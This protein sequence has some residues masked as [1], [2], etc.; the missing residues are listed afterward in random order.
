MDLNTVFFT[1]F[2]LY[3]VIY[4]VIAQG[5]RYNDVE[6]NLLPTQNDISSQFRLKASEKGVRL[7]YLNLKIGN[8][9][10]HPL[11]LHDEYLA[12][13][14]VWANNITEPML[15]L[16]DDYDILSLGLLNYQVRSIDVY[17][18][19]QPS[20]CLASLNS[21]RQNLAVGRMLLENVTTE[22]S[23]DQLSRK[24][25]VHVV[26]VAVIEDNVGYRGIVYRCC[27]IKTL[28][29][30]QPYGPSM[31]QCD[32]TVE[33]SSHWM[34]M[35]SVI[36][37]VMSLFMT[38]YLPALPLA[39][40]DCIFSLQYECDKEDGAEA[41][42]IDS[43][44]AESAIRRRN[45][46]E[47]ISGSRE[48]EG[49]QGE[50]SRGKVEE[51]EASEIPVDDSSPVTCSAL[52]QAYIQ[53]LP[54]SRLSFNIKLAVMLYCIL[55]CVFYV[56]IGLWLTFKKKYIYES[57]KKQVQLSRQTTSLITFYL[58]YFPYFYVLPALAGLALLIFLRPKDLLFRHEM[59]WLCRRYFPL[60]IIPFPTPTVY[61]PR[62][63]PDS[64]GN[65]I[66]WH[67]RRVQQLPAF[68]W[69]TSTQLH[70]RLWEKLLSFS[71]C[72]LSM[73][74][75]HESRLK[76]ALCVLCVLFFTLPA[77]LIGLFGECLILL[78]LIVIVC[79][80]LILFSPCAILLLLFMIGVQ[81]K[82]N[83]RRYGVNRN[84]R[85]RK[86]LV[87]TISFVSSASIVFV[88]LFHLLMNSTSFVTY[89]LGFI[90]IGLYLN[91][92][93][94]RPYVA[95][96]LVVITNIYL[97]YANLQNRYREFKGLLLK[98]HQKHNINNGDQ[99]TIPTSLFWFVS[100]R[101]LPIATETCQM[102]CNMTL[103]LIF[104]SLF[105]CA[106]LFFKETYS[107][108]S[109]TSTVSVFVS[110]VIP[111]LFFKG[112]TKGEVFSGWEKIK[113]KREIK[114]AVEEF[115]PEKP[116]ANSASGSMESLEVL[117]Q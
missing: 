9:S 31:I 97:C 83:P 111:G 82:L 23:A 89:M 54:D 32:L 75:H 53:K 39:L 57:F 60:R 99:D 3:F 103:I 50:L 92:D 114:I 37:N 68:F 110:G 76:G 107:I 49:V 35:F 10:H 17:L 28:R 44:E 22:R 27:Y 11:E 80:L 116:G 64:I 101:V 1:A 77:I 18:E 63:S 84:D 15:T 14:W 56:E 65:E 104:L 26:C 62:K 29:A 113:M 12:D 74:N 66:L 71:T 109:V 95:F 67:L 6:C 81:M 33:K 61:F 117:I 88:P 48:E 41:E 52:L 59:G 51:T 58:G 4:A 87:L 30:D 55:P 94:V 106:V 108:S 36:L 38:L 7:V 96:F 24:S 90:L 100:D 91:A 112:I 115:D 20:G 40:P 13:R 70:M 78:I 79:L 25:E 2:L 69:T 105:L 93:I 16:S 19:D 47:K 72:L 73:V 86:L 21:T 5:G 102:L 45:G 8:V 34:D 46:Y 43:G 85:S 98:Y 42:T